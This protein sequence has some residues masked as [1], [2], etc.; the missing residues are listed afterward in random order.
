MLASQ[1]EIGVWVQAPGAPP[2]KA[3][4]HAG[5]GCGRGDTL[6]QQGECRSHVFPLEM[7][8][9]LDVWQSVI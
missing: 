8:P 2:C 5:G 9:A 1:A 7:T 3:F 6:K 4:G